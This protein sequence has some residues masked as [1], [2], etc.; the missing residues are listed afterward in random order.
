MHSVQATYT[1]EAMHA[2][3]DASGMTELVHPH[4]FRLEIELASTELDGQGCVIDFLELDEMVEDVLEPLSGIDLSE[5]PL[6][7]G[8]SASAEVI[9]QV[10]F[11]EIDA[12][13]VEH[14]AYIQKVT[15][16]EDRHHAGCYRRGR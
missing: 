2:L 16:W 8:R 3:R 5:H 12:K 9:A 10:L 14:S 6:F 7:E 1:L 13:F 4:A 11:R 15:V